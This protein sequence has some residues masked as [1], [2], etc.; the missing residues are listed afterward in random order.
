[1]TTEIP[2]SQVTAGVMLIRGALTHHARPTSERPR[3]QFPVLGQH[4]GWDLET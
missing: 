2:N 1:M 3:S 4:S